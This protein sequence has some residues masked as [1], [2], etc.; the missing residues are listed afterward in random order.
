MVKLLS[1][2]TS[3]VPQV[4]FNFLELTSP[5]ILGQG[6]TSWLHGR[7]NSKYQRLHF[8][9]LSKSSFWSNGQVATAKN[10]AVDFWKITLLSFLA[11]MKLICP[12]VSDHSCFRDG[13]VWAQ[14]TSRLSQ[15]IKITFFFRHW[16][17]ANFDPSACNV[18][19]ARN[20]KAKQ[21]AHR[22]LLLSSDSDSAS[23]TK[24][25]ALFLFFTASLSASLFTI[26]QK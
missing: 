8:Y 7:S 21:A 11:L 19:W 4:I 3:G 25:I 15:W 9:P 6:P 20:I 2:R 17:L 22:S 23:Q 13:K 12:H 18:W 26:F 14:G 16:F 24:E 10:M 1:E 5:S